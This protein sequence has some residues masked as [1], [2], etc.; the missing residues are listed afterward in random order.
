MAIAALF[1][2]LPM[3]ARAQGIQKIRQVD[4]T[5]FDSA[6]TSEGRIALPLTIF[7]RAC[8]AI[9]LT[10]DAQPKETVV[11][12]PFLI[13]FHQTVR[14]P[15]IATDSPAQPIQVQIGNLTVRVDAILVSLLLQTE[16]LDKQTLKVFNRNGVSYIPVNPDAYSELKEFY[17]AC[18]YD[19]KPAD[20]KSLRVCRDRQDQILQKFP[21]VRS[22]LM[23]PAG[24]TIETHLYSAEWDDK[25][26]GCLVVFFVAR[27]SED[28][29]D[30]LAM[31][32]DFNPGVTVQK[33]F[34]RQV[35]TDDEKTRAQTDFGARDIA[36]VRTEGQWNSD[37]ALWVLTQGATS[38]EGYL[39]LLLTYHDDRVKPTDSFRVT[40]ALALGITK[41]RGALLHADYL[42]GT[43]VQ[44]DRFCNN[45]P[46]TQT[47]KGDTASPSK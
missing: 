11:E 7:Q 6:Y 32:A 26:K 29:F 14:C 42:Q 27:P 12:R 33:L 43:P 41:P 5:L 38:R 13:F 10:Y 24:V 40:F 34:P 9:R 45:A 23:T 22:V 2:L 16:L 3:L 15:Q 37:Y 1:L 46:V 31:R 30:T 8:D 28:D 47:D 39:G 35:T 44:T 21:K 19:V 17:D 20:P 18:V 36:G 4:K 25:N